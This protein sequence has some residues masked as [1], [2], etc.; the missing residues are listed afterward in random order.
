MNNTKKKIDVSNFKKTLSNEQLNFILSHTNIVSNIA[1]RG[2]DNTKIFDDFFETFPNKQ[3]YVFEVLSKLLENCSKTV[4]LK[5]IL[6]TEKYK[7]YVNVEKVLHN[8]FVTNFG[9]EIYP[10][11]N[12]LIKNIAT[13]EECGYP[14]SREI[15]NVISLQ[16]IREFMVYSGQTKAELIEYSYFE[17]MLKN[18]KISNYSI[19]FFVS[20]FIDGYDNNSSRP[21]FT[22]K[23]LML[24]KVTDAFLSLP[25]TKQFDINIALK[26]TDIRFIIEKIDSKARDI[27]DC[28]YTYEKKAINAIKQDIRTH[29]QMFCNL[30]KDVTDPK[31][32]LAISKMGQKKR[33]KNEFILVEQELL[34]NQISSK[35][36]NTNKLTVEKKI[37]KV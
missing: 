17:D 36:I 5:H 35:S 8:I 24:K 37:H 32:F 14:I 19:S 22:K 31:L 4:L 33:L 11:T 9:N 20:A 13:I 10:G 15:K 2:K 23:E 1:H 28:D 3:K 30:I 29:T 7:K 18:S 26:T 21:N 12:F 27:E 25:K 34:N 16:G 6:N